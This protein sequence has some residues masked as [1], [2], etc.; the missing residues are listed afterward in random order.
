[1]S[2]RRLGGI[3]NNF[4]SLVLGT[5]DVREFAPFGRTST[6]DGKVRTLLD[7][8]M[9]AV[10]PLVTEPEDS[11]VS[12]Y[13]FFDPETDMRV[14]ASAAF[15]ASASI[16]KVKT[17]GYP[18]WRRVVGKWAGFLVQRTVVGHEA[19]TDCHFLWVVVVWTFET[20]IADACY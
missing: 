3:A 15:S 8:L 14:L 13:P 19:R 2:C 17:D 12:A 9:F 6:G 1:M 11:K 5:Y 16:G 18:F 4:L 10:D 20:V 7:V